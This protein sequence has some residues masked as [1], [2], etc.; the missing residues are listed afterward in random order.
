MRPASRFSYLFGL[1][2][3]FAAACGTS[4]N[5]PALRD[6]GSDVPDAGGADE[7]ING[8]GD[9]SPGQDDFD[10]G[11]SPGD[12]T[13]DGDD[14]GGATGD[15]AD[16][17]ADGDG[18][19]DEP[20]LSAL[21][22]VCTPGFELDLRDTNPT[23]VGYFMDAM[24][25][26]PEATVQAIGRAVCKV[27]YR[28]PEEVRDATHLTLI[29]EHA[30]GEVAWKAGDG[31]DITVM[32]STDHIQNVVNQGRDVAKEIKGVLYH[33][34]T[35]MYQH[36]D[37]DGNGVDLGL[38]EGIADFVRFSAGYVPDGAQPNPNG[39][40]NDGYRTTAFFLVWVDENYPDFVYKLNLSMSNK[41]GKA[42]SPDS[43]KDITG[44]T[45]DELWAQYKAT[46]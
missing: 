32:I 31:G 4:S 29:I 25:G 40:W 3:S 41:D 17:G 5:G 21:D 10:S 15:D 22:P 20:D 35:H 44:Y 36:D 39:N 38:I 42:W 7:G 46:F 1:S 14:N 13:P 28:K 23:R 6:D 33:E 8:G 37:S 45:A 11:L 18:G 26:D 34:M 16:A 43:F 12:D 27:L 9:T 30:V 19:D 24:D 2:F